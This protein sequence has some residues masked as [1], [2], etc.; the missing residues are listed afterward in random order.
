MAIGTNIWIK[1]MY[2]KYWD[3]DLKKYKFGEILPEILFNIGYAD[4][5]FDHIE[6]LIE[7]SISAGIS[8]PLQLKKNVENKSKFHERCY[9]QYFINL[10]SMLF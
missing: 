8:M 5:N 4:M 6:N 3:L 10:I 9:C 2:E 1:Q 7:L